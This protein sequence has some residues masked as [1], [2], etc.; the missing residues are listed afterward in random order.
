MRLP[1]VLDAAEIRVL[2]ALLEKEQTTPEYYPLTIKAL[3][4][5]CAQRSNREPVMDLSEVDVRQALERLREHALVW[6]SDGARVE[7]W[8]H[9]LDRRWDLD[10]A[11]KA[12]I[13][14]LL[15]RGSQTPGELRTRTERM[16]GFP[17]PAEVERVLRA[18]AAEEEPLVV[19]IPR[20]PGQKEARWTHLAGGEV[21]AAAPSVAARAAAPGTALEER[22]RRLEDRV[23]ELEIL[24]GRQGA[25]GRD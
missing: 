10:R 8:E 22:L 21:E 12:L 19:E 4:A 14:V 11:S 5:A 13:T 16:H 7:R 18:L 2:G 3:V 24:V 23:A 6:R 25:A 1:R 9:N 17:S 15:L 20:Q